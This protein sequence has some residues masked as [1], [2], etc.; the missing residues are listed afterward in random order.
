M[1][2]PLMGMHYLIKKYFYFISDQ[3]GVVSIWSLSTKRTEFTLDGHSNKSILNV[4]YLKN[5]TLLR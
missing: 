2:Q 5:N 1:N 3:K 4:R